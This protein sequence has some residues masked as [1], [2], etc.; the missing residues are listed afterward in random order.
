MCGL[1]PKYYHCPIPQVNHPCQ[2]LAGATTHVSQKFPIVLEIDKQAFGYGKD[3]L[4]VGCL[5]QTSSSTHRALAF[6]PA[7]VATGAEIPSFT[8]KG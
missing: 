7:V 4:A 1:D 5:L 6:H 3:V 2:S 8:G